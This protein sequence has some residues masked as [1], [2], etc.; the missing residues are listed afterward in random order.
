[1]R[2]EAIP[3]Q[4]ADSDAHN[5]DEITDH[6]NPSIETAVGIAEFQDET[7]PKKSDEKSPV[8][9]GRISDKIEVRNLLEEQALIDSTLEGWRFQMCLSL[10]LSQLEA[11]IVSTSLVSI[12]DS[13]RAF[14]I[15]SWVVTVYLL[16]YT[17]R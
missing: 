13:L 14:S 1:M 10:F 4:D 17:G 8:D 5:S 7:P 9:A 12:T 6:E 15:S 3:R 16:T 11:K 2:T